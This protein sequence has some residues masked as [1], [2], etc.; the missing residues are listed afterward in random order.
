MSRRH[1][2]CGLTL[3]EL[4]VGVALLAILLALAA[5]SF[6]AQLAAAQLTSATNA[7][8][9]SLLQARAQAIRVGQRV[10]VCRSVDLQQ[11]DTDKTHGWD[12]GWLI[13]ID[14]D[15][16][17]TNQAEVSASD[18]ILTRSEALPPLLRVR[19][20]AQVDDYISFAA[21]GEARTLSG[22][23]NPLGTIR[24]CSTSAQLPDTR[25]SRDLILSAGGRVVV[26]TPAAGTTSSCPAP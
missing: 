8:M 25:R 18:T 17:V 2:L 7:L 23:S 9:G 21:S 19:G 20:N 15:R 10:T 3:V 4:L 11:C 16:T 13:F 24:V 14:V 26:E 6:Q 5:P 22:G 1:A 12:S